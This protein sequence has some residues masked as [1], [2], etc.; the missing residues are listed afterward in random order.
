MLR[1]IKQLSTKSLKS[2]FPGHD[3]LE[4]VKALSKIPFDSPLGANACEIV[5]KSKTTTVVFAPEEL[6]SLN[7]SYA[8]QQSFQGYLCN[9]SDTGVIKKESAKKLVD[10]GI[11]YQHL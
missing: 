4:D 6:T 3:A 1:P 11:G 9:S 7:H 5:N 2:D 10:S 8:L